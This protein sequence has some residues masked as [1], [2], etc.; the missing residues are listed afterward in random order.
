MDWGKNELQPV[1]PPGLIQRILAQM[2][3]P[4]ILVLLGAAGLSLAASGGQDWLDAVIILVI[5]V[6]NS[7]ISITQEDHAQKALEALKKMTSPTACCIRD[8][9]KVKLAAR[10]LVP[11]DVI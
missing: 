2:R 7:I 4:M 3:D 5:V 11:G 1:K 8:G 6:V 9:R 10:V